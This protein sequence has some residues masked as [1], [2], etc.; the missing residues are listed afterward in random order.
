MDASYAHLVLTVVVAEVLLILL[1]FRHVR[2]HLLPIIE[3]IT[4]AKSLESEVR[5]M[6]L[7]YPEFNLI[8]TEEE[9]SSTVQELRRTRDATLM[10]LAVGWC[11]AVSLPLVSGWALI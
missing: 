11:S 9:T 3:R 2:T 7:R 5:S 10:R 8:D 1:S 6:I 4:T